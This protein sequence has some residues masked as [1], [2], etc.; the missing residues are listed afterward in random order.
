MKDGLEITLKD[1]D[2]ISDD[3]LTDDRHIRIVLKSLLPG[4]EV[5]L[6]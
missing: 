5:L 3:Q 2:V 1:C 4:R 6:Q